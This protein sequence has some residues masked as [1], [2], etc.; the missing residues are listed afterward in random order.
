MAKFDM[1]SFDEVA[2]VSGKERKID[3]GEK[4]KKEKVDCTERRTAAVGDG[5]VLEKL[6]VRYG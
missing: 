5:K 4:K 1:K 3:E 2:A 6:T